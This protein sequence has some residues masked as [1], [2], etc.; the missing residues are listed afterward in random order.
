MD[1]KVTTGP[2]TEPVTASECK[3]WAHIDTTADDTVIGQMLIAAREWA[4]QYTNRAFITQS[5]TSKLDAWTNPIIIPQPRL[6]TVTSINYIDQDGTSQLLSTGVY[7]VD[8]TSEP[9]EI[10]LKYNQTWPTLRGDHHGITIVTTNGYG[11]ATVVPTRIKS[12]IMML[13][14]NMD[15][16]R[17][18]TSAVQLHEVPFAVKNLLGIDRIVT[19]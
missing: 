3:A 7:D 19:I 1:W 9:G 4:E 17:E 15:I 18:A 8:V 14:A 13:V 6:I 11:A 5:I 12:A 2:A 16:N 10:F